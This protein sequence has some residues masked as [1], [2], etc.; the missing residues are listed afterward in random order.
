MSPRLRDHRGRFCKKPPPIDPELV[1]LACQ[2]L[3]PAYQPWDYRQWRLEIIAKTRYTT[4][5]DHH[6]LLE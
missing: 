5:E 3:P 6:G 1:R 4:T 2:G